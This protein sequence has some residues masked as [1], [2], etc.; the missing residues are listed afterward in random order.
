[1]IDNCINFFTGASA[2]KELIFAARRISAERALALGM[3]GTV[4][5]AGMAQ[6]EA[7]LMA[8]SIAKRGPI[9][10]RAAKDAIDR[11]LQV[12]VRV[13]MKK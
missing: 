6:K 5:A 3:V 7:L 9:A 1:M 11:G 2:A 13:Y 10:V 12:C 4:V 8:G